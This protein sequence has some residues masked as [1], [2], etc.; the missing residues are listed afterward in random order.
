MEKR[1]FQVVLLKAGFPAVL[2]ALSGLG[3]QAEESARGFSVTKGDELAVIQA[4]AAGGDGD[5]QFDLGCKYDN[6]DGVARDPAAAVKWYRQAAESGNPDA[7]YNLGIMFSNGEGVAQDLAEA[8]KWWCKAAK[9][10]CSGAQNELGLMYASGVG[11]IK[12]PAEA[13]N[14]FRRA[15]E[16][17]NADAQSNLGLMYAFGLGVKKDE[18]EALA[19]FEISA[20][21]GVELAARN[22]AALERRLDRPALQAA[23]QRRAE[24][25]KQIAANKSRVG[26]DWG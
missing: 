22:R 24:L 10:G 3:S 4:K 21:S 16:R 2:F 17:G 14:W 19:W 13:V 9:Q 6:G 7:Q 18:I 23:Q 26:L 25:L 11:A 5:A 20:A 12:D 8:V 1:K 15:A